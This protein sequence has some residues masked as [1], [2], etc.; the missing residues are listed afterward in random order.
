MIH[1]ATSD[2]GTSAREPFSLR[3]CAAWAAHN[4]GN[5]DYLLCGGGYGI[6]AHRNIFPS[7]T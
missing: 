7:L 2:Q 5:E 1:A 3:W 4:R 6:G